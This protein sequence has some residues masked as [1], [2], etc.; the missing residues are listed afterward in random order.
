MTRNWA[1][2]TESESVH[3]SVQFRCSIMSNSLDHMDRSAPGLSVHH[4]LP[5][6][7]QT[8]VHWVSDAIQP[9]HPLLSPSPPALNLLH[10]GLFKWVS[11][12]HQVVSCQLF[13]APWTITHRGPLSME[14]SSQAYWSGLLFPTLG[15]LPDPEIKPGSS[16]LWSDSLPSEPP[17]KQSIRSIL[18]KFPTLN[19]C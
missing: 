5:E 14:F 3:Q 7:T 9:S 13:L 16:T 19:F 1:G 10:Q 2:E 11:S 15:Y 4:Q 17:G 12:S 18:I 6:F 8:H